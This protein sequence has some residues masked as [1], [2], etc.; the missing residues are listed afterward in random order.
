MIKRYSMP[1]EAIA[2]E[3]VLSLIMTKEQIELIKADEESTLPDFKNIRVTETT[4]G[5]V[6]L[7][8]QDK[9]ITNEETQESE[10]V[11]KGLTY[12]V[13]VVW[14]T[15]IITEF[16]ERTKEPYTVVVSKEPTE[17]VKFGVTPFTPNHTF[18]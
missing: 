3:L 7:G 5:I 2:H 12:D 11:H 14:R 8:F 16:D 18:A 13:D 4:K 1:S 6:I 17:W 10:L 9:Y 15:E